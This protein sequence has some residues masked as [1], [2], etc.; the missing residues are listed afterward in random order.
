[1]VGSRGFRQTRRSLFILVALVC[2]LGLPRGARATEGALPRPSGPPSIASKDLRPGMKG[3]GLTVI[4]GTKIERFD[5]EVIGVLENAM[6][7]QDMI[8]I[9]CEG[10]GLDHSGIVAGMSGSPVFI[11]DAVKGDLLVGALSY[12]FPFNKD[13]VAGVTPIANML[14]EMERK[15]VPVPVNQRV[16]PASKS[17]AQAVHL[18]T[19]GDLMPVDVPLVL[20]GFAPDVVDAMRGPL[21]DLGFP[22]VQLATGGSS[23]PSTTTPRFEPGSA[24]SL[25]LLRGDMTMTGI[26]TVTW[27]DGEHFI[28]F[29]HPFKGLGQVHLPV[30][31]ADIQWILNSVSSSFKMGYALGDVGVLDQD[32]QSAIAGRMDA[33]ATMVPIRVVVTNRDR[34][35]SHTWNVEVT[36]QPLFFPLAAS[37]VVGN[38]V[39]SSEP[40]AENVAL[41][42]K[43]RFDLGKAHAPIELEETV[44]GLSGMSSVGEVGGLVMNVAKALVYNG[45]ERLRVERIDASVEVA[46]DRNVAFLEAVRPQSEEVD[47]G[48]PIPLRVRL[49]RPNADAVWVT[50]TLPPL[51]RDLAGSTLQVQVGAEKNLAPEQAEPATI[52]DVLTF[53]RTQIPRNRLAAVVTLPEPTLMLRGARLVG[54]PLA[55]RDEVAG[56]Q[57]QLRAGKETLRTHIDLPWT[58]NGTVTLKLRVRPLS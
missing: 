9:R 31:G 7:L 8:L 27:V 4:R 28:A 6:P 20:S 45:F 17:S 16:V 38:A 39:R 18:P 29:G 33:R 49:N 10:L 35:D 57:V 30:G 13:P 12:G 56:H 5:I 48:E 44:T 11:H 23:R 1:M 19:G 50:L 25:S 53:L 32:R 36:D 46:D 54:L 51:S 15:L 42:M 58:L 47:V 21:R 22:V 34:Q 3:Y 43:L 24:I 55:V 2:S 52:E 41:S 14:P 37:M 26:G 40:I